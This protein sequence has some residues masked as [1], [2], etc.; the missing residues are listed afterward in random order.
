MFG[1]NDGKFSETTSGVKTACGG[2]M[3]HV[4]DGF[5]EKKSNGGTQWYQQDRVYSGSEDMISMCLPTSIPGGSYWYA[6]C[7]D[8]LYANR[9]PRYYIEE[10]PTLRAARSGLKVQI[11]SMNSVFQKEKNE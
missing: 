9:E 3:P 8:D 10:T 2:E 1:R 6:I 11:I 4:I 7:I 5:G